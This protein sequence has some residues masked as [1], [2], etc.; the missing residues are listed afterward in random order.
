[1]NIIDILILA[2][3]AMIALT[4]D[5]IIEQEKQSVFTTL[6]L[7]TASILSSLPLMGLIGFIVYKIV[8]MLRKRV[9]CSH[10]KDEGSENIEAVEQENLRISGDYEL[11]DRV[12]HPRQYEDT[13]LNYTI[14][15]DQN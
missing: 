14:Q 8:S 6:Y 9:S 12:L 15:N 4:T 2:D 10:W 1:M 5:K 13:R 7:L 11:P 3:I